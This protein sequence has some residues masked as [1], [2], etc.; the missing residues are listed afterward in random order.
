MNDWSSSVLPAALGIRSR[1][2]RA[3]SSCSASERILVRGFSG[4]GSGERAGTGEG[5]GEESEG[6][7]SLM[8]MEGAA[9]LT[10]GM[11]WCRC[12]I[13]LVALLL[14]RP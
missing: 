10:T 6:L 1:N 8:A 11:L 13:G 14:F 5:I 9:L 2:F 4:G 7:A 12:R 3:A